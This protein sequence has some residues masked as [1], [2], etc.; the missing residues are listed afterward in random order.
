MTML[1]I[2]NVLFHSNQPPTHSKNYSDLNG[3]KWYQIF[4][5]I[6]GNTKARQIEWAPFLL[7][8]CHETSCSLKPKVLENPFTRSKPD[9][10]FK[11]K[12]ITLINTHSMFWCSRNEQFTCV[13][14]CMLPSCHC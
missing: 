1:K 3:P 4:E 10:I 7:K 6:S 14:I 9:E 11:G 13:I 2:P 8:K 12:I 5:G